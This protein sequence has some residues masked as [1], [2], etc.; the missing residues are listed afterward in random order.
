MVLNSP[1]GAP[2]VVVE[3]E[4]PKAGQDLLCRLAKPADD[5]DADPVTYSFRWMA[6]SKVLAAD[7]KEPFRLP[8]VGTKKGQSYQCEASASDAQ[9]KGPPASAEARYQNTPPTPPTVR[10]TPEAPTGGT[11]LACEIVKGSV[12]PDGD[13]VKYRFVWQKN[14]VDQSFAASSAEVPA[15]LVKSGDVWRC[16]VTPTDG[17]D[18]GQASSS[19]ELLVRAAK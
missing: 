1:P 7:P 11:A 3:P 16:L 18:D 10:L 5:P 9:A 15:R 4:N 13:G 14:G 6:G 12:D 2:K 19:L 17:E 8:A